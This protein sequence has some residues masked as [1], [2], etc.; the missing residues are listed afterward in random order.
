MANSKRENLLVLITPFITSKQ[1]IKIK[2]SMVENEKL[3]F[4]EL[5]SRILVK[6]DL[7]KIK[8]HLL[9]T[10]KEEALKQHPF[11]TKVDLINLKDKINMKGMLEGN[12]SDFIAIYN[13]HEQLIRAYLRSL[14][15]PDIICCPDE[16]HI[17]TFMK[18]RKALPNFR[19]EESVKNRLRRIAYSLYA[20]CVRKIDDTPIIFKPSDLIDEEGGLPSSID[21]I[22]CMQNCLDQS[23]KPARNKN[24][25]IEGLTLYAI[26]ATFKEIAERLKIA[27]PGAA[28]V[29]INSCK[30]KLTEQEQLRDCLEDCS[31]KVKY[32]ETYSHVK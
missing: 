19:G 17:D 13:R 24:K 32:K 3:N 18:F 12:E 4:W 28:R 16:I 26:G 14:Y 2:G 10:S 22:L 5:I 30:K 8:D 7:I 11:I 9:N 29:F 27:T 31:S 6:K 15:Y 21:R 20:S 25:C 23:L 1:L